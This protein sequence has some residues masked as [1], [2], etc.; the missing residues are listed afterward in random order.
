VILTASWGTI[1]THVRPTAINW[2]TLAETS[3]PRDSMLYFKNSFFLL[4]LNNYGLLRVQCILPSVFFK[5]R[6]IVHLTAVAPNWFVT[7]A[8]C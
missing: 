1:P 8:I 3:W 7:E 2:L 4:R 6:N 5:Y